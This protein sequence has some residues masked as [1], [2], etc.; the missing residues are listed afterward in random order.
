MEFCW[1]YREWKRNS[2]NQNGETAFFDAETN[3]QPNEQQNFDYELKKEIY[4]LFH[5]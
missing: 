1:I 4:S 2:T 3:K 5:E